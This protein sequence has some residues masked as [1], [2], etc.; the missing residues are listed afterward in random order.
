MAATIQIAE[1]KIKSK[2]VNLN[3]VVVFLYYWYRKSSLKG[4]KI[5][6]YI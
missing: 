4:S 1:T 3:Y 5:N 2:Y 6:D